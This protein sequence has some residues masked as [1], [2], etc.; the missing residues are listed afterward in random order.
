[1]CGDYKDDW[2][3]ME[4]QAWLIVAAPAL[5]AALEEVMPHLEELGHEGNSLET[6]WK[7]EAA[8]I[9]LRLARGEV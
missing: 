2:E 3:R 1:V 4:A 5:Y 6:R 9:A 7:H 8:V